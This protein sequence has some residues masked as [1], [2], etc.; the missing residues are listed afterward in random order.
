MTLL[1]H[2]ARGPDAP[3]CSTS[4]ATGTRVAV[5]TAAETLTY[6]DLARPRRRRRRAPRR[7]PPAGARRGRQHASTSLVAYLAA[8]THGHVVL[9][10]PP[11]EPRPRLA[12]AWDPDVVVRRRTTCVSGATAPRHD[13]HPDLALL[14]STSG[15]TGSPK[16]VRLSHDNLRSNAASIADYLGL[17]P[18]DRAITSLPL[19]YCYGLS[20]RAQPPAGRRRAGADRPVRRRRVL[21]AARRATPARRRSPACPTP[22]SCSSG[23]ASTS[24]GS[25]RLRYVTQAGGRLAPDRVRAW[26]GSRPARGLGPGRDV[27]RRPRRPP[28]WPGCRPSW[29]T[30]HPGSIG[31]PV[32]GGSFR[33][34][35]GAGGR[36]PGVGELV[37]SGPNVM[38]G[39]ATSAGR[40]RPRPRADRAPHRR[41]RPRGRR[42]GRG[43]RAAAA[44]TPSCSGCGSTSTT[45]SGWWPSSPAA[46]GALRGRRRRRSTRSTPG[47]ARVDR[48]A[49]VVA[50]CSGLPTS[51][52]RVTRLDAL[53]RTV[54]GKPDLA[55]L[56]EH[57]RLLDDPP[58]RRH[59]ARS[60][61]P[62]ATTTPSSSGGPTSPTTDSFAGLGGDSLSYVELAT[63]LGSPARTCRPTGTP[64]RSATWLTADEPAPR[65]T[66]RHQRGAAGRWPS[67]RSSAPTPTCS[68]SSA[69][70]TCCSP[71]PATTSP[72]SS[73]PATPASGGSAT[74]WP[75]SRSWSS[76]RRCGSAASRWSPATTPPPPRCSSTGWSAATA[77]PS[78]GSTGSSR[79]W[80]GS[81]L[82]AL[83]LRGG[84]RRSTGWS[85]VRRARFALGLVLAALAVRFA[86]VGLEAGTTERYTIGVVAL[87]FALRL[88]RDPRRHARPPLDRRGAGR[89]SAPSASSAT[90]CARRWSS[91]G[92]ALLVHVPTL[93]VPA[94]AGR[95]GLGGGV[96]V[97]VRLP[98][99]L[100]GLPAPRG[101]ASRSARR[102]RRSPSASRY[103]WVSRPPCAG[104]AGRSRL[105][106][107]A[108]SRRR[109]T[110]VG[111]DPTAAAPRRRPS[112]R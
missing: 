78:S 46:R 57:A 100:A 85:G 95:A 107:R 42:P 80:S 21:L 30:P 88:G 36:R 5:R 32:P 87:W 45:S 47:R 79:P 82:V 28:G 50:A 2:P 9:L 65:R 22:S 19:H 34:R 99:P 13:L 83:A 112:R 25:R 38:L 3:R 31:I 55:A 77:G 59:P 15:S 11:G 81:P 62:P 54:T 41:P 6:A 23:P 74:G 96:G 72:A 93:R 52:I 109:S 98:H 60:S 39:Y 40:P 33:H 10:A 103:W 71:S 104:S 91:A 70:P 29:P 58:R 44:G 37:Y 26:R 105:S 75:R 12:E 102:W 24:A 18:D 97:A 64:A 56:A 101:R 68:P 86:W 73:S 106:H 51:A 43:G 76:R 69:A 48:L 7:H 17:T 67:W 90:R 61:R 53:P 4:P 111:T 84:A 49:A 35:P 66:A 1:L 20:V 108:P 89:G 63:R 92:I 8:L 27:R 110:A 16:L 94:P 14:L